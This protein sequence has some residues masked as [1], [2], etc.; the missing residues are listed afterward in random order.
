MI[1]NGIRA[2]IKTSQVCAASSGPHNCRATALVT[3]QNGSQESDKAM[4]TPPRNVKQTE[5]LTP[6][7][8]LMAHAEIGVLTCAACCGEK[9]SLSLSDPLL[10]VKSLS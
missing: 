1:L 4:R 8:E 6:G 5:R 3:C 9:V 2:S 7:C 10:P